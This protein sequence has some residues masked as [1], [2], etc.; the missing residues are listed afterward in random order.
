[1]FGLLQFGNIA[2]L[3]GLAL[4]SL[5]VIIHL[6]NKRRF[7]EVHW[8]AMEFLL[9]AER[10]NRRRIK[11][12]H[13]LLLLLRCLLVA[14]IVLAV[15]RPRVGRGTLLAN[16]AGTSATDRIVIW[17]DSLSMGHLDGS[18]TA[19]ER[20]RTDLLKLLPRF[21][22]DW[23]SDTLTLVRA[24]RPAS[25]D[26]VRFSPRGERLKEAEEAV[27]RAAVTGRSLDLPAC[28]EAA[29]EKTASAARVP[30]ALYL[31]SDFRRRDFP[32]AGSGEGS[33]I[34]NAFKKLEK[35]GCTFYFLDRGG[36]DAENVGVVEV[37]SE[38]PLVAAGIPVSFSARLK[39]FGTSPAG[40]LEVTFRTPEGSRPAGTIP[41]VPPGGEAVKVTPLLFS[42]PG[43]SWVEASVTV[44]RLPADSVRATAFEVTEG[45]PVLLVNGEQKNEPFGDETDF[46]AFALSPR[47]SVPSGV[48]P[49][50]ILDRAL[51]PGAF[52]KFPVV[53][54][55]NVERLPEDVLGALER[56]V[57]DGAGLVVFPGARID[58]EAYRGELYKAG[59]GLLPC[60]IL[61]PRATDRGV[62]VRLSP[63]GIDPRGPLR[64]FAG[65][66]DN[67]PSVKT[68]EVSRYFALEEPAKDSGAEVLARFNTPAREPFLVRRPHGKGRVYLFAVAADREGSNWPT[69][70]SYLATTL[71]LIL[72]AGARAKAP[73]DV[74]PGTPLSVTY[75]AAKSER[76]VAFR[77]PGDPPPKPVEVDGGPVEG[78][79][80]FRA[81][82]SGTEAAGV[83]TAAVKDRERG[84]VLHHFAVS[85]EPDEGDLKRIRRE[86]I[87]Q[88]LPGLKGVRWVDRIEDLFRVSEP[89]EGEIWRSLVELFVFLLACEA[90]LA[91]RFGRSG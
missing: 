2:M 72:D 90:L 86:E 41:L 44:D 29:R 42:A 11:L 4:V 83:Y 50:E 81:E 76:R 55:A 60:P 47:G 65:E 78:T 66:G 88:L 48:K 43:T 40:P 28:L 52:E 70:P 56:H 67:N 77:L 71:P 49:E 8:A 91:W 45:L 30:R 13:L 31:F 25:P 59:K 82:F 32:A 37:A 74:R 61:E 39:N 75:P 23:R 63:E 57:A 6:L 21:G 80:D 10:K 3:G 15:A 17:D 33:G 16:A 14:L 85:P 84:E 34:E 35:E 19:F 36:N 79:G 69:L 58:P 7:K 22:I 27:R 9:Q 46:L 87:A 51:H 68:L 5:P 18:E 26:L 12:E 20:C 24:S 38:E 1:M 89:E 54:L 53:V 73:R 64:I 62:F